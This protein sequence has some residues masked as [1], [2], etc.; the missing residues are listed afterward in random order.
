[1]SARVVDLGL[2]QAALALLDRAVE[3][4]PE[5]TTARAR[6]RLSAWL[7]EPPTPPFGPAGDREGLEPASS[8][9][10]AS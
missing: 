5:L 1:M 4:H 7:E 2:R 9:R 3:Q 8:L 10:T 6:E